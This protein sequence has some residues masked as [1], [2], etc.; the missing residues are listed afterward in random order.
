MQ[1]RKFAE[2]LALLGASLLL[3]WHLAQGLCRITFLSDT[4]LLGCGHNI[5]FAFVVAAA[6]SFVVLRCLFGML[7][8]NSRNEK[9][10]G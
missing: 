9:G 10:N 1:M 2:T 3:G 5:V 7:V 4:V 6:L 8:R